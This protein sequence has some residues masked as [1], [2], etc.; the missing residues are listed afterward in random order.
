ML[1]HSLSRYYE[2]GMQGI[3]SCQRDW[4]PFVA[5]FTSFR[6]ME[7]LRR[8]VDT[9]VA[10]RPVH[11]AQW[12]VEQLAIADGQSFEVFQAIVAAGVIRAARPG[13]D[14]NMPECVCLSECNLPSL[15]SHAERYGRFGFVLR[16]TDVYASG[17]RPCG[18]ISQEYRDL[19]RQAFYRA[20]RDNDEDRTEWG[21]L[22]ALT[23][24]YRPFGCGGQ[25]QDFA[26]E[27]EWR[28][29]GHVGLRAVPP[30]AVL[31][32]SAYLE[33]VRNSVPAVHE[34]ISLDH[35]FDW[36]A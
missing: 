10:T 29:F 2:G 35:L 9:N 5:H 18:Y 28:H 21:R 25:V 8:V 17:G 6:A 12:V 15:I 32:P 33:R 26:H 1:V 4:S 30:V 22:L 16:K 34:L 14:E 11:D 23:H 3:Q 31:C 20:Q 13:G 36:G 7:P 19:V 24:V 27:R